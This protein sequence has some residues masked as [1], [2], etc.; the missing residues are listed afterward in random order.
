MKRTRDEKFTNAGRTTVNM[1]LGKPITEEDKKDRE[2][3]K[4]LHNKA[5]EVNG[6]N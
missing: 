5:K 2:K 4:E 1:I 3:F 6:K